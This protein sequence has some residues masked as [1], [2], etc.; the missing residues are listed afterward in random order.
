MAADWL[1]TFNAF[2]EDTCVVGTVAYG[3]TRTKA[4]GAF[5]EGSTPERRTLLGLIFGVLASTEVIFPGAR[6]PYVFHILII[7]L[8]QFAGGVEVS[9]P[10]ILTVFA[11]G[12]VLRSPSEALQ[13]LTA[14]VV[15]AG[16]VALVTRWWKRS[17]T[18]MLVCATGA[19][20][21]GVAIAMRNWILPALGGVRLEP[22]HSVSV[23]ANMF[24][25]FIAMIVWGDAQ[26]RLKSEQN[27]LD[28]EHVR[29][30][31]VAA[32][33]AALRARIRPHFLFNTLTAIAALCDIDPRKAQSAVVRVSHLMRRHIDVEE[34]S[35]I[36]A[37][38]ELD[39]VRTY[40]EI[41]LMRFGSKAQVLYEVPTINGELRLPAFSIQTLV[42]NAFQHGIE[43]KSGQGTVRIV[44]RDR[45]N[46]FWCAV[47]DDGAGMTL[48][49]LGTCVPEEKNPKHGLVIVNTELQSLFGRTGRLRVFSEQGVGTCV[50]FRVPKA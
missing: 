7:C 27:R 48:E 18:T 19:I 29:T 13:T 12:L 8:A 39:Y 21:Q 35:L 38:S 36:L 5:F 17:P 22:Y 47:I 11:A 43:K 37:E 2:I 31:V 6:S 1:G 40:S 14:L 44:I 25:L 46:Y 9:L 50:A 3:L 34:T 45:P 41:Q 32:E 20:A 16:I 30:L 26:T 42:E 49:E 10:A 33:L 24:G 28:A 4:L 23:L 15:T